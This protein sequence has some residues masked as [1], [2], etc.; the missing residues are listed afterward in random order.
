MNSS[1]P[2]WCC[3][4]TRPGNGP[5]PAG[6]LTCIRMALPSESDS[7]HFEVIIQ[8]LFRSAVFQ[9]TGRFS[10]ESERKL[11]Q[12][13][14]ERL[15]TR[16]ALAS[17]AWISQLAA[18]DEDASQPRIVGAVKVI[19]FAIADVK[20]LFRFKAMVLQGGVEDLRIRFGIADPAGHEYLLEKWSDAEAVKN[21]HQAR[22]EVRDHARMQST[23]L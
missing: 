3:M 1:T 8:V 17:A 13:I 15:Q 7:C 11:R 4:T 6:A 22:I 21:R 12:E 9:A 14:E 2:P 10:V 18:V 23:L 20:R 19:N 5:A 16:Y